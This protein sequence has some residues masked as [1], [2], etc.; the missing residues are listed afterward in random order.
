MVP[1]DEGRIVI[2]GG[3]RYPTANDIP[4]YEAAQLPDQAPVPPA[5]AATNQPAAN[6]TN[7]PSS[8]KTATQSSVN[9]KDKKKP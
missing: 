4:P 5:V 6:A 9:A 2:R 3:R 1:N 8:K 7:K